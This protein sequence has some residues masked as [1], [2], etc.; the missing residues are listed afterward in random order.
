MKTIPILIMITLLTSC[1][2]IQDKNNSQNKESNTNQPMIQMAER[3]KI[4][5]LHNALMKLQN[6]NTEYPFIGI[7]SNGIDC[8]YFVFENGKFNIEFEAMVEEQIPFVDKLKNFANT[9]NFKWAMTTYN[10]KPQ[11]KSEKSAP[12]LRIETNSTLDDITRIGEKIQ[13]ELFKN[14]NETL[15]DIV[16]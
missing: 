4:N 12:V 5:G 3:I 10:N 15:F 7:T 9:N 16:P 2:Q 1:G 8:I 11:Y 13:I 6:G 14:N